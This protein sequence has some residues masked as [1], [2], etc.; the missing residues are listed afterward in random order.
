MCQL[1]TSA[2]SWSGDQAGGEVG[3]SNLSASSLFVQHQQKSVSVPLLLSTTSPPARVTYHHHHPWWVKW[4]CCCCCCCLRA[5]PNDYFEKSN[6]TYFPRV[7]SFFLLSRVGRTNVLTRPGGGRRSRRP[8]WR[9]SWTGSAGWE[10]SRRWWLWWWRHHHRMKCVYLEFNR[11]RQRYLI[12]GVFRRGIERRI[13]VRCKNIIQAKKKCSNSRFYL[14]PSLLPH[15]F[16]MENHFSYF[17]TEVH[18]YGSMLFHCRRICIKIILNI[19][20]WI[21]EANNRKLRQFS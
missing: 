19:K 3:N 12:T 6:P 14:L 20:G 15:T 2:R 13:T 4:F 7:C 16:K 8:Q 21:F 17:N 9:R 18:T 11:H 1:V 10:V 5:R